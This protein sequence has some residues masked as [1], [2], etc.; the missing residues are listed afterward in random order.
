MLKEV[1]TRSFVLP[2]SPSHHESTFVELWIWMSEMPITEVLLYLRYSL[3]KRFNLVCLSLLTFHTFSGVSLF[4]LTIHPLCRYSTDMPYT[5]YRRNAVSRLLSFQ[6]FP[7]F[8]RQWPRFHCS[9]FTYYRY[10]DM[11]TGWW[12]VKR[13]SRV[14]AGS[15][16]CKFTQQ[17][18]TLHNTHFNTQKE[19]ATLGKILILDTKKCVTCRY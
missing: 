2:Y 4:S 6:G 19:P 11:Y 1:I 15:F 12:A 8:S 13:T 14:E 9:R 3:F 7:R 17:M 16:F 5:W 10:I 18:W